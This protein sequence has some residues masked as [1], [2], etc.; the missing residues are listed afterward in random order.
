[1]HSSFVGRGH[2]L[3]HGFPCYL[4]V[5]HPGLIHPQRAMTLI[6]AFLVREMSFS[7]GAMVSAMPF[8][9]LPYCLYETFVF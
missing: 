3:G 5:T 2:G 9:A 4:T 8:P 1:M 7:A 6:M